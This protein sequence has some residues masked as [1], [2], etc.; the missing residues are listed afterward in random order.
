MT[1]AKTFLTWAAIVGL[2]MISAG[3]MGYV[4]GVGMSVGLFDGAAYQRAATD[5][6]EE[7]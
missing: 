3:V 2:T 5:Q 6:G 7:G 1:T 4:A